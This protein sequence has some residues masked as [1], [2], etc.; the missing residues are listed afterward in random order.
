MR[1]VVKAHTMLLARDEHACLSGIAEGL[2]QHVERP[3]ASLRQSHC[4][5]PSGHKFGSLFAQQ[6]MLP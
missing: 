3:L 1:N 6:C 5:R 2:E 4:V